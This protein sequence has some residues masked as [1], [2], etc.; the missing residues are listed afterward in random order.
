[1]WRYY[2]A[3]TA[4]VAAFLFVISLH[5]EGPP[6]LRVSGR[7][8]GTPSP[9]RS[10]ST[11][12]DGR[13]NVVGDAPWA[14]SALP[15]CARQHFATRGTAAEV[16]AKIPAAA[17]VVQGE[18]VAGPCSITVTPRGIVVVRGLDRLRI[19][20]PA[21]LLHAGDRYYLYRRSG[22]RAEVR[23]Y[24]LTGAR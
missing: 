18:I 5:R 17:T 8:S 16:R 20:P 6:D 24:T 23:A 15:D 14:L 13:G 19:P 7:S 1:M 2:V 10:E 3:A 12:G 4:I 11:G 22:E 21:Q 9:A